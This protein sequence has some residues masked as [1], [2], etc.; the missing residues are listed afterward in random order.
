MK[1]VFGP[2]PSRRLGQ[3]LGIDPIPFKTCN[4]NCVYCQLGRTSPFTIEPR[5]FYPPDEIVA[6]V[7]AAIDIHGARDIDWIT[8]V[9]SGEPTLHASLGRMIRDVKALTKIPVA[10]LTNGSLLYEEE[11]R[12]ELAAADAVLPSLD[13]GSAGLFRKINRP[14]RQ[15]TFELQVDGLRA[16]RRA[17]GGKLWVE[18]M[19]VKGLND[20]PEALTDL[21]SVLSHVA[22]DEIHVTLP[23]RPP[24]ETWVKPADQEGLMRASEVLGQ[25]A[26]VLPPTEEGTFDLSGYDNV[27]D[28]VIG[29]ITRH[30]MREAQLVQTLDHWTPGQVTQALQELAASNRARVVTR[31]GQR[32]WAPVDARF[33]GQAQRKHQTEE[34][35]GGASDRHDPRTSRGKVRP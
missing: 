12:Q 19:L 27:V 24:A 7:K 31:H 28:A 8:F 4:W 23:T 25:I 3:S 26:R 30:P 16:F 18:T 1:P 33:A 20:T 2:V 14:A 22:P 6:A 29:V 10:V 17:Y 21:A 9:G 34:S 35:V 5:D 13:A 15:F 11:V 32:F